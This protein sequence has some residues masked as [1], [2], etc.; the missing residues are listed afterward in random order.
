VTTGAPSAEFQR[1][2]SWSVLRE[3]SSAPRLIGGSR[4]GRV[5][6]SSGRNPGLS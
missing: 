6:V 3:A 4:D 1:W 5:M 2:S